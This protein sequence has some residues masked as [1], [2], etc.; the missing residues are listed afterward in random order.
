M[1]TPH[2]ADTPHTWTLLTH[3][4]PSHMDTPHTAHTPHTAD[5]PHTWTPLTQ[6]H[7]SYSV[8]PSHKDTPHT[9]T[10]L[11]DTPHTVHIP[12]TVDTP[13]TR[14]SLTQQIFF[15]QRTLLIQGH[16]SHTCYLSL[17]GYS[18]QVSLYSPAVLELLLGPG[19][20][21][22]YLDQATSA[23]AVLGLK[24]RDTLGFSHIFL[25]VKVAFN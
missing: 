21:P 17:V 1:D 16:P 3:G 5:T 23:S 2:T 12:H 6:G 14:T 22:L 9:W 8:H 24:E 4:H 13:Y 25:R 10:P 15:I 20:L 18:R 19:C 7:P 11:T